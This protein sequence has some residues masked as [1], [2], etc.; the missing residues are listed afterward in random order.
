M[1]SEEGFQGFWRGVDGVFEE[2]VR[3]F[4]VFVKVLQNH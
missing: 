3:G 4:E 1:N 2:V